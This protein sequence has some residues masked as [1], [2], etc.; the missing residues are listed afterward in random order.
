TWAVIA[1]IL[2]MAFVGGLMGPYMRPIPIGASLAM[3]FSLFIAFVLSPWA[4][5]RMLAGA[6]AS[7]A[8][9]GEVQEG[10]TT[11]LY[12]RIMMP[13]LEN[14][15]K[16]RAFL[17]AVVFLL[18]LSLM[19]PILNIVRVKMLP[20]DNKSEMQVIL[21]MPDGTTLEQTTRVARELARRIAQQPEVVNYQVYAGASGPYNFN[22]LVRHYFL[23]REPY[24]ADIQ[25]N[26][27]PQHQRSAQSHEI[28]R[29]LRPQLDE[30]AAPYGARIKVAEVPPGP[31]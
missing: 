30:I 7:A 10:W 4:G 27:L 31:P 9:G 13:L 18:A 5:L 2:P 29:R 25:V 20:F 17:V 24:Q 11:R 1:A 23:R 19:L 6:K 26:L 21:D 22:G 16:R 3:L 28:A 12:R 15:T 8:E 14:P